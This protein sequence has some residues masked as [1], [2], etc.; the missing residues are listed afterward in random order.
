[1]HRYV[2]LVLALMISATS[3]AAPPLE[4]V[5]QLQPGASLEVALNTLNKA[6]YRIA[7]SSTVVLPSMTLKS[8]PSAADIDG[9]LR[10]MLT[11]WGLQA[12]RGYNGDWLVSK[13]TSETPPSNLKTESDTILE[14]VNVTGSRYQVVDQA[15]S[16]S[17]L[18]R[19]EVARTPHLLD[20]SIRI[21]KGFP[22]VTGGDL[23]A[24]LNIRGGRRDEVQ[25]LV[26]GAEIHNGFHFSEFGG[27]LSV[28]DTHLTQSIDL[29]TGGMTADRS[30][31]MSGVVDI[32]TLKPKPDDEYK[33]VAGISFIDAYARASSTFAD[34]DGTWLVSARRGY[35]DLL[36]GL[37]TG[38]KNSFTPR[39][40]DVVSSATY[41]LSDNTSLSAHILLGSDSLT[42]SNNSTQ[43]VDNNARS[44]HFWINLDN[45]WSNVLTTHTNFTVAQSDTGR[46]VHD[47]K[48]YDV[49]ATVHESNDFEYLS[50]R[51]DWSWMV[52]RND[53]LKWGIN[54][55]RDSADYHYDRQSTL[56][57]PFVPG[58]PM[59]TSF[60]AEPTTQGSRYGAFAAYKRRFVD[61][62]FLEL[63]GR[64]DH[65]E[66]PDHVD[67]NYVSPRANLLYQ[68]TD[69]CSI[70][71]AWGIVYQP[72]GIDQLQIEDG[73]THYFAP[74]HVTHSV[75]GFTQRFGS[76]LSFRVDLYNK[77]YANLHPY[78]DNLGNFIQAVPEASADRIQV[79]ASRARSSGA[80]FVLRHDAPEHFSGWISY[81]YSHLREFE[82]GISYR[83]SW[84]Q[85]HTVQANINWTGANWNFGMTGIYHSGA[86]ITNIDVYHGSTGSNITVG[87][88]NGSNLDAYERVDIR[89]SRNVRFSHSNLSFYFEVINL[90]DNV[91]ECCSEIDVYRDTVGNY[92]AKEASDTWL[93]R[94]PSIGVQIEF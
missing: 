1:M 7:Y 11:P 59:D 91:N 18:D 67:Y 57:N 16:G 71:A 32:A 81:A 3:H 53:L 46:A 25:L 69:D 20:D 21:L 5:A 74:E 35:M 66:Y 82:D 41:K 14:E 60:A 88:R 70:R 24:Q 52:S 36:V 54:A 79:N 73:V 48:Q 87:K 47:L 94:L 30:N 9:V 43:S 31:Y 65:A 34:G 84:D 51:Q 58:T 17:F 10:E 29:T 13:K 77:E 15:Y 86:P 55:E 76:T 33:Y 26:D 50:F 28:V 44:S 42:H 92:Y 37:V 27:I 64:W 85:T 8:Q 63:G 61:Q 19:Q 83:R 12:T 39:F 2:L 78:F 40:Q 22:G 4:V 6:G 68:I 49:D 38:D 72:Q 23:S 93:P 89:V 56:L 62:L 75:L 90:F 80:E 45:Q